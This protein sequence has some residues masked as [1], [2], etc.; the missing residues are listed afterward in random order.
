MIVVLVMMLNDDRRALYKGLTRRCARWLSD[1]TIYRHATHTRS[2]NDIFS[3]TAV[4]VHVLSNA[5]LL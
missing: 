3:I 4:V 5:T 1:C 2:V